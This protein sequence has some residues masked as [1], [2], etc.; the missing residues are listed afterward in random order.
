MQIEIYA[1]VL[2]LINF[3]MIFFI[4]TCVNKINKP[5]VKLFRIILT[6]SI[7][8]ILY[9]LLLIFVKYNK[10]INIISILIIISFS[11]LFCFR[12]SSLNDF[13]KIL[14][15]I[16][17]FSV[18]IGGF[19]IYIFYLK[20]SFKISNFDLNNFSYKILVFSTILSYILIKQFERW[21]K[22]TIVKKQTFY[23]IK[24]FNDNKYVLLNALLD[25]GNSLKD[26]LSQ[27]DVLIVEFL[28]I[29]DILPA[30]INVIFS[31]NKEN[32]MLEII[33]NLKD[34]NFRLIPFSSVGKENGL[35]LGIK[36]DKVEIKYDK[37]IVLKNVI[38]GLCNFSLSKDNFY[39][40][41]LSP[42][43]LIY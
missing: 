35:M 13:F 36:L 1:D 5:K 17:G 21:Y 16:L 20:S 23:K 31:E 26:P 22:K 12:P 29:K 9:C 25:T 6:S 33:N 4:F 38:V 30:C 32:D 18:F 11:V 7:S 40:A 39:R 37:K 24:I 19:C 34:I 10:I 41:I 27:K 28:A 2:Y 42:E 8:S 14:L 43:M 3:F 15:M